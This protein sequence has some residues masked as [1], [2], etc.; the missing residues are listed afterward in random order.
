MLRDQATTLRFDRYVLDCISIDNGIGQGD[1]LS[2]VLYQYY[3]TDL[4]DIPK[5]ND[6][7]E[8]TKAYMD[9]TFMLAS[10]KDFQSVMGPTRLLTCLIG[11]V[12]PT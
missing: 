6:N 2:I 1:P 3:N 8:D 7:E 12:A 5:L 4:L 10:A 9:N 11:H